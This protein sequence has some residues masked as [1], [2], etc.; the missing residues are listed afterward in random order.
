MGWLGVAA[1]LLWGMFVGCGGSSSTEA[2][3][4]APPVFHGPRF[5]G[6]FIQPGTAAAYTDGKWRTE[7]KCMK[8]AGV[9]ELVVQWTLDSKA[10]R[11]VYPT[12]LTRATMTTDALGPCFSAARV[13]G[14]DVYLGLQSND[15]WWTNY[16]GDGDWL[17]HEAV[18]SNRLADDLFH[19]Y[20]ASPAF[21][22]WYLWFEVDNVN[23]PSTADWDNLARYFKS[24]CDHLHTL[25]PG[26]RVIIAPFFA[27]SP[28]AGGMDS[29]GW[30]A[31]W[32]YILAKAPIDVIA[33][34]DG[35][36]AG[37]AMAADLPAW[38]GATKNA[39]ATRNGSCQL[40]AD[41]ENFR[42]ED[43]SPMSLDEVVAHMKAV[44]PYVSHYLS[45][46][47]N[48]YTSPQAVNP[49][50]YTTYL[51][52][53]L[54][55]TLDGSAPGTPKD[56]T[57]A[58]AD[59]S[60]IHLSWTVPT[61]NVGVAGYNLYRDGIARRVN[62]TAPRVDDFNLDPATTYSYQLSAFDAAGNESP[63]TD[64]VVVT[65]PVDPVYP[66]NLAAGRPYT[67][68]PAPGDTYPDDGVKLT[69]GKFGTA[70]WSADSAWVGSLQATY[71]IQVDLG[72]V[73]IINEVNSTWLQDQ[74]SYIFFPSS[75][76]Y[77]VS[78]NGTDFTL[79]G[80]VNQPS[81]PVFNKK[82]KLTNLAVQGRYV[83]IE[84][85]S[86]GWSFVDEVEVRQQ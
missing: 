60:T 64:A 39:V 73:K 24:V 59:S 79:V 34:Q 86:G 69:D 6:S 52:Y 23:E 53:V 83:R 57:G 81:S 82:C 10:M 43:N 71:S 63:L 1:L 68:D 11:A 49:F 22:G 20:G 12:T 32:E 16:A 76:A 62:A 40:W 85:V 84:V 74:A 27:T 26:K 72:A 15:D 61:D 66:T 46:S 54:S 65:T 67:I 56:L 19:Q 36:G 13:A 78:E 51:D 8:A 7:F 44:E 70:D 37:N 38:F 80:T 25:A 28:D 21:K 29:A 30:Q 33:L 55:G 3:P 41:T 5:N 77:S 17:D 42:I 48:H 31:M 45:F 4:P 75:V 18:I 2:A 35:V 50:F 9:D 14:V 47:F 58:A